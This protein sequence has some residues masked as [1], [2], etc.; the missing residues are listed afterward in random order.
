MSNQWTPLK[1][2]APSPL[3]SRQVSEYNDDRL[4]IRPMMTESDYMNNPDLMQPLGTV[5]GVV[6]KPTFIT[7]NLNTL[8]Y[9]K[10]NLRQLHKKLYAEYCKDTNAKKTERE[11][12]NFFLK[13]VDCFK[14]RGNLN[15]YVTVEF[16]ATEFN[17]IHLALETI[18]A[19]FSAECRK[20]FPYQT[21]NP[22]KVDY[23][24]GS[25][26]EKVLK[27]GFDLSH[28]DMQTLDMWR[29]SITNVS[30]GIYRDN[31]KIPIYRRSLHM[32]HIDRSN[33]GLRANNPDRASVEN[34]IPQ[35]YNMD[36]IK[37]THLNY[38]DEKWFGLT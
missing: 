13:Q 25:L 37:N 33:E 2:I 15:N 8:F 17:N 32:R 35:R 38:K 11:F 26:E 6:N 36:K 20:Y 24:V 23:E 3:S 22:F 12:A 28:T 29:A 21:H 14:A 7:Q 27:K 30:N 18:N 1:Q 4:T 34:F 10:Q 19:D 16:Q 9:S 31:N 5:K